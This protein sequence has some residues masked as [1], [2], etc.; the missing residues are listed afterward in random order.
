M[1][2]GSSGNTTKRIRDHKKGAFRDNFYVDN[3]V[4]T[5]RYNELENT[6]RRYSDKHVKYNGQT[7]IIQYSDYSKIRDIYNETD[8][9]CKLL[10]YNASNELE[11]KR[12]ELETERVKLEQEKTRQLE[13][14]HHLELRIKLK[15][16]EIEE[17]KLKQ[18]K[19][20]PQ[21]PSPSAQPEE[22]SYIRKFIEENI[23]KVCVPRS[24][25]TKQELRKYILTRTDIKQRYYEQHIVDKID[26][27]YI[28]NEIQQTF[29]VI[30]FSGGNRFNNIKYKGLL[31][32]RFK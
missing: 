28:M 13:T 4:E 18:Q 26:I 21:D 20:E 10:T 7:E 23:E 9:E 15:E 19:Q 5:Y 6:L 3:I 14:E 29:N 22:N 16:L 12:I 17:L 30:E 2:F 31:G 25:T 24:I 8:Q 27:D 11:V 32:L 1:K